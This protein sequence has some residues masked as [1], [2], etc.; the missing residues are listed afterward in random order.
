M[1]TTPPAKGATKKA[2]T[3]PAAAATD[4]DKKPRAA[5]KDYGYHPEAIIAI[6]PEDAEKPRK[7]RGQRADWFEKLV[8]AEGKTVK[9]FLDKNQGKDSPRGWLR[10]F[11]AEGF[12]TL[13]A[14]KK[15]A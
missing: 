12:V 13:T 15:A 8:K 9:E 2:A 14:P 4:G 6:V 1:G 7:F 11:A 10:F 5:K 3:P